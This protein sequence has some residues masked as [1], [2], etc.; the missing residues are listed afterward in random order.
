MKLVLPQFAEADAGFFSQQHRNT[1][2]GRI[3]YVSAI[4]SNYV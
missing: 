2:R 1:T 4:N 3:Y